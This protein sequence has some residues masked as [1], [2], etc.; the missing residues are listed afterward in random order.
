[1]NPLLQHNENRNLTVISGRQCV[2]MIRWLLI[3]H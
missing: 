3:G 2:E 1:M